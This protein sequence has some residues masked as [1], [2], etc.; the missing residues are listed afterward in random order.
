[1]NTFLH[2]TEAQDAILTAGDQSKSDFLARQLRAAG[3]AQAN[4]T[5]KTCEIHH[6]DGFVWDACEPRS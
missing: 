2:I 5:G 6:P 3:Q 4:A 1:M